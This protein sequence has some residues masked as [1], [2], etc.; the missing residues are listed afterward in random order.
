MVEVFLK[1]EMRRGEGTAEVR[2]ALMVRRD[3]ESG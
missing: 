1:I 3:H 2:I